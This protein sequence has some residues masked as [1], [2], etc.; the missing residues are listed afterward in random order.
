MRRVQDDDPPRPSGVD[1]DLTT[2]IAT[3]LAKEPADRPASV[4]EML[5]PVQEWLETS[6]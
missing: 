4:D 1:R 2:V 5:E 6:A 3:C